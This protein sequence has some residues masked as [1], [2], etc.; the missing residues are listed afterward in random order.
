MELFTVIY[1]WKIK[2]NAELRQRY[3]ERELVYFVRKKK[4]VDWMTRACGTNTRKQD[5]EKNCCKGNR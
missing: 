1:W 2:T 5:S 3:S 4:P